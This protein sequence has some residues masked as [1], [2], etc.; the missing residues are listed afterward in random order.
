MKIPYKKM[1]GTGN[2]ILI[3]DQRIENTLPPSAD[4]LRVLS[5]EK[6]GPGFDQLMWI[7]QSTSNKYFATYRVFN[8]DGSEAEQCGNGVR[9]VAKYLSELERNIKS[10]SLLSPAGSVIANIYEDDLVEVS[11]GI[12]K[13]EPMEIPFL[14]KEKKLLYGLNIDNK[15]IEINALS[16]GNPHAVMQV[17]N[18][19][20]APVDKIGPL[21]ENH[22]NFPNRTN[23]GFMQ[24]IDRNNIELRVHERG[25]GETAACG[26]GACAAVISGQK[27][28]FLDN[29]VNVQLLGGR[30]MVKWYKDNEPV[31]LKGNAVPISDGFIE[32]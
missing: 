27:L 32:L 15:E 21:I 30:V 16:L 29:E 4:T 20:N 23:V 14:A 18:I 19:N 11:M 10:L 22:S 9:C 17:E 28:G 13:F 3:I 31:W 1:Q 8:R 7:G 5:N 24:I 6:T 26:T 25:A 12:P 2:I